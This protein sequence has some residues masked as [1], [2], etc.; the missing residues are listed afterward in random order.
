VECAG[1]TVAS[2]A[3]AP[4]HLCVFE[5]FATGVSANRGVVDPTNDAAPDVSA[6]R[7]GSAVYSSCNAASCLVEGTWAVTAP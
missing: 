6:L 5:G 1:G 7:F 3:A 2:P 4:G